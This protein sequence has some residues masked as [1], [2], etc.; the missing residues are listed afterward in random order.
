MTVFTVSSQ[1]KHEREG[2][3]L[4][5]HALDEYVRGVVHWSCG[6]VWVMHA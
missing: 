3:G 6:G 4:D 1:K 2:Q 5:G